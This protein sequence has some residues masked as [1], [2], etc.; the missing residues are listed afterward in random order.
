MKRR[1]FLLICFFA[2]MA[3]FPIVSL[4]FNS[5]AGTQ[6]SGN[7]TAEAVCNAAYSFCAGTYCDDAIHAVTD[8]IY[9]NI[10]AGHTYK[11]SQ[12]SD[13]ELYERILKIYNS[14]SEILCTNGKIL[15]IPVCK[16]SNGSTQNSGKYKYLNS[17]A[18][19]WDCFSENYSSDNKCEGVSTDGI[20]YL[21]KNGFS[22]KD[23][24]KWYLPDL[25]D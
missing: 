19:P 17:A 4:N 10:K 3:L 1:I 11:K 20:D 21:C 13:K 22:K 12:I 8:I 2:A 24:L 16:C 9:T 15:Y 23:A 6:K 18:S 5:A 14:N 25:S 7:D